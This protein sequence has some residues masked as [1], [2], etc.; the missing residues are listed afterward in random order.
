MADVH[1]RVPDELLEAARTAMSLP[2][3]ASGPVVLRASLATSAG[4]PA[5]AV[6]VAARARGAERDGGGM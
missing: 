3:D 4:W 2:E 1:A 5:E 6:A